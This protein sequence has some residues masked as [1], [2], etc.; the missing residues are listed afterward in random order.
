MSSS[1]SLGTEISRGSSGSVAG[2]TSS[3]VAVDGSSRLGESASSSSISSSASGR[4]GL[5]SGAAMSS[6]TASSNSSV[7]MGVARTAAVGGASGRGVACGSD[8]GGAAGTRRGVGAVS[9]SS[10]RPSSLSFPSLKKSSVV[11]VGGGGTKVDVSGGAAFRRG[12]E[13]VARPAGSIATGSRRA[14]PS[15][16]ERGASRPRS[17]P[18]PVTAPGIVGTT[19]RSRIGCRSRWFSSS[20]FF[21]SV[22]SPRAGGG[23]GSSVP[24]ERFRPKIFPSSPPREL[25]SWAYAGGAE[26]SARAYPGSLASSSP[27][28]E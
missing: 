7:S 17:A 23:S 15:R 20:D 27:A 19:G 12:P 2:S 16:A 1:S 18:P 10:A 8:C 21:F 4:A 14:V 3:S 25:R 13:M 28:S 24:L 6:S 26:R 22:R 5:V 11:S 9:R